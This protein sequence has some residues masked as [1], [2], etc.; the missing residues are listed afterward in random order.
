MVVPGKMKRPKAPAGFI[1]FKWK[2][3]N[4]GGNSIVLCPGCGKFDG[5]ISNSRDSK[6]GWQ[7]KTANALA[8]HSEKKDL[9]RNKGEWSNMLVKIDGVYLRD[10]WSRFGMEKCLG[11]GILIWHDFVSNTGDSTGSWNYYFK[12][13]GQQILGE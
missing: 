7:D 8:K 5:F 1:P 6:G 13:K 9:G 2:H 12:P 10:H 11:R 4:Q 3:Q